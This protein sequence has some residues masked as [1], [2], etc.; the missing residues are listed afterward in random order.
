L[1]GVG[2]V[3]SDR[4]EDLLRAIN[5]EQTP[6]IYYAS[7]DPGYYFGW[8]LWNEAGTLLFF[9]Q[10][11]GWEAIKFV[12]KALPETIKHYIAEAY[13]VNPN[14]KHGGSTVPAVRALGMISMTADLKSAAMHEQPNT[15]KTIGYA[16][17]KVQPP[18]DHSK[19]HFWDAIAHGEFYMF[20]NRVR[21]NYAKRVEDAANEVSLRQTPNNGDILSS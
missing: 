7:F 18:K 17:L 11:E 8:A 5:K 1:F 9:G 6:P 14:I 2:G 10:E 4:Q 19:S 20:A 12:L 15:K 16:R 21:Q 13:R 3:V